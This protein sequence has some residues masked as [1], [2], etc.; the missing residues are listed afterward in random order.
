MS[1]QAAA[2]DAPVLIH[3]PS[4]VACAV[5]CR[6]ALAY[7]ETISCHSERRGGCQCQSGVHGRIEGET[8]R[9]LVSVGQLSQQQRTRLVYYLFQAAAVRE[10]SQPGSVASA[11]S[12]SQG[13]IRKRNVTNGTR[14]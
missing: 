14:F 10:R 4:A 3:L 7:Q 11:C 9:A 5:P 2:G 12:G 13:R 8:R 1:R 6:A